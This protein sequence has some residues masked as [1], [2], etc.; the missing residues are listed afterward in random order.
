MASIFTARSEVRFLFPDYVFLYLSKRLCLKSIY[1]Q[2]FFGIH[3]FRIIRISINRHSLLRNAV[4]TFCNNP[5]KV[6]M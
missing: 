6:W 5:T 4:L 3:I 2:L 1:V